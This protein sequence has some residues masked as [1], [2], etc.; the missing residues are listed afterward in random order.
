M[1]T[2]RKLNESALRGIYD[3]YMHEAFPPAELK[4]LAVMLRL[5]ERGRYLC[6]GYY[7]NG[8]LAAYA[9]FYRHDSR[10]LLLDYFAVTPELRGRGVG[11]AFLAALD[12]VLGGVCILGEVEMPDSHDAGLN[13]MRL[14]R[15]AFYERAGF[16]LTGAASPPDSVQYSAVTTLSSTGNSS[17][18]KPCW[19]RSIT[20]F[21]AVVG[22]WVPDA[23]FSAKP[24]S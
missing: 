11:S 3:A 7:R 6:Y 13:A 21:Q 2:V 24:E 16:S 19:A 23:V 22:A 14:R 12:A 4:P 9:F 8:R 15:I 17:T 5:M 18:G 20:Y 1:S 10:V